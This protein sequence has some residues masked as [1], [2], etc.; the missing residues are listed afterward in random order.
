MLLP[1][2]GLLLVEQLYRNTPVD[3][4][5]AI[6]F[7]CLGLGGAF[8]YDFYLYADALLFHR[9]DPAIWA[10]R[11]AIYALVVPLLAVAVKR[12]AQ[13]SVSIFASKTIVFHSATL[14]GAGAYLLLM[15]AAG[16]Y[17]SGQ[18]CTASSRVA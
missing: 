12:N 4:R 6:K 2:G 9:L 1:V 7:L 13:W 3:R 15:A 5:W 8:A 18:D 16:Y 17:N 14:V 11:G 10:A